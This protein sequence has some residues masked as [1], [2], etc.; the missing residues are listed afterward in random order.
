[1]AS[2]QH[3]DVQRAVPFFYTNKKQLRVLVRGLSRWCRCRRCWW[4]WGWISEADFDRRDKKNWFTFFP[5]SMSKNHPT[6]FLN[7]FP[8]KIASLAPFWVT[9][10]NH[11]DPYLSLSTGSVFSSKFE[12]RNRPFYDLV[13]ESMVAHVDSG[14]TNLDDFECWLR[15]FHSERDDSGRGFGEFF[16]ER[17]LFSFP[18]GKERYTWFPKKNNVHE[19]GDESCR[20]ITL[21]MNVFFLVSRCPARLFFGTLLTLWL[22]G[23]LSSVRCCEFAANLLVNSQDD[24][25]FANNRTRVYNAAWP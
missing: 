20:W 13:K 11:L 4:C 22:L 12:A 23:D 15:Q 5:W 19:N 17:M 18:Q 10:M 21:K 25:W 8:E 9:Q 7:T 16:L 6:L 1:M 14:K 24:E 2:D 3:F